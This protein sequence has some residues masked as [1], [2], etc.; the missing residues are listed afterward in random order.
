MSEVEV[1]VGVCVCKCGK[2]CL[3]SHFC[4][5]SEDEG[6]SADIVIQKL[7]KK[8]DI[9]SLSLK[10]YGKCKSYWWLLGHSQVGIAAGV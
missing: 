9:N 5:E 4:V 7:K 6:F 8:T 3:V 2:H 10:K 1:H